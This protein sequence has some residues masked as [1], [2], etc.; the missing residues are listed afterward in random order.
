MEELRAELLE[1]AA[2]CVNG[3]ILYNLRQSIEELRG[4]PNEEEMLRKLLN[5]THAV[6]EARSKRKKAADTAAS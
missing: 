2:R 3:A 6:S 5:I 4:K 1:V